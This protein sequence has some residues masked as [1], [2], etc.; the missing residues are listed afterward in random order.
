MFL[1]ESFAKDRVVWKNSAAALTPRGIMAVSKYV[2]LLKLCMFLCSHHPN[3]NS[4]HC[5]FASG[6][7]L[8][9]ILRGSLRLPA[10]TSGGS[11]ASFKGSS[12]I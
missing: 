11:L 4:F 10:T 2:N 1:K 8:A 12:L 3:I 9:S 6:L 7:P 5:V